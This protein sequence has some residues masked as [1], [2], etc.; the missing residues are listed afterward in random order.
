MDGNVVAVQRI[1]PAPPERIFALLA[2][3]TQ[4]QTLDG[5]GTVRSAGDGSGQPLREGSVFGMSMRMGLSYSTINTVVE[6]E[7]DRRIAWQT[8]GAGLLRH[9]VGGR[10]WRY[11][12]EPVDG[13]TQ[14]RESWDLSR[15]KQRLLISRSSIPAATQKNIARTLERIEEA[16]TSR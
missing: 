15:D 9:V 4:H 16:V 5:S 8:T 6:Y 12:L 10:V 2:D 11:E 1:I 7:Q 14:V 3:A 13:G